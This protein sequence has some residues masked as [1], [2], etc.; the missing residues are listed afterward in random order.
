MM[1]VFEEIAQETAPVDESDSRKRYKGICPVCGKELYICKSLAMLMG[2]NTGHGS[3]LECG[4]FL[5]MEFN[6]ERQEM[7]LEP[8]EEYV[9]R[10]Q[11]KRDADAVA[12]SIGYGG[13]FTDDEQ[14]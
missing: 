8:F 10:E 14:K 6:E 2:I 7:D 5:H 4:T 12:E 13:I 11:A 9:K 3:C 1:E